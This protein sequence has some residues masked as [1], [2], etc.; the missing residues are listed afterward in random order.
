MWIELFSKHVSMALFLED[1]GPKHANWSNEKSTLWDGSDHE[2]LYQSN[3][4]DPKN[5]ALLEKY[6]WIDTTIEYRFNQQRFRADEFDN[7][8]CGLSL[9]CSFTRGIGLKEEQTWPTVLSKISGLHF[10]NLGVGGGAMDTCTRL[11]DYYIVKL[12]PR[13]V[14]LLAPPKNR[15]ELHN[16]GFWHV[17]GINALNFQDFQK[18]YYTYDENSIINHRRNMLA[19]KQICAQH[20]TPFY[21]WEGT[22][23]RAFLPVGESDAARDLLHQGPCSQQR[24]AEAMYQK[25]AP[26]IARL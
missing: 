24:L 17:M 5:C 20:N 9:G 25:I 15:F 11:L 7:R 22:N 4:K 14:I 6:G 8:N 2:K 18:V 13:I 10:W 19:M 3:I 21:S 1:P 23:N 26:E 16:D 12:K